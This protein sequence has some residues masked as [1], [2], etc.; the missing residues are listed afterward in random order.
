MIKV[1]IN[2][3]GYKIQEMNLEHTTWSFALNVPE[4]FTQNSSFIHEG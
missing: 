4:F 1:R 2:A 3:L